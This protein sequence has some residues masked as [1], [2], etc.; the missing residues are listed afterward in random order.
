MGE[1]IL[2]CDLFGETIYD[3]LQ[4]CNSECSIVNV[5]DSTSEFEGQW[6]RSATD[7]GLYQSTNQTLVDSG[8]QLTFCDDDLSWHLGNVFFFISY[9]T[10]KKIN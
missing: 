8:I 10:N 1:T 6:V 2:N 3:R 9:H 5:A 4:L 7:V